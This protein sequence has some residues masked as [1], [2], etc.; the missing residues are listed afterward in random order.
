MIYIFSR[1]MEIKLGEWA[2]PTN[3]SGPIGIQFDP[4]SGKLYFAENNTKKIGRL[5]LSTNSFT[6]WSI[7][8]TP[9]IIS[10]DSQGN[11]YFVAKEEIGRFS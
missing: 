7:D 5:D 8:V 11:V 10:V 2:I 6:E 3:S 9:S 1:K 4:S